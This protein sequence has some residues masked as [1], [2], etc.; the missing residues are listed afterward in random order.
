VAITR[1]ADQ[2]ASFNRTDNSF[3]T[4][5]KA[6][7]GHLLNRHPRWGLLDVYAATIPSLPFKAALH[8]N[9]AETLLPMKDDLPKFRDLPKE[10]GGTAE[11]LAT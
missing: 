3:R 8:V 2:V 9:Y 11:L 10:L 4:W 5:C 7:G 1:G 6:C